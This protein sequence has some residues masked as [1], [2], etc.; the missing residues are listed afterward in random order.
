MTFGPLSS[1]LV[2]RFGCRIV[3]VTGCII[4]AISVLATSFVRNLSDMYGSFSLFYG[5]GTCLCISPIMTIA[6]DYFDKYITVAV[7]IITAGSSIGTLVMAPLSQVLIDTIGWRN[8]FRFFTGTCIF[9]AVC[10]SF[11]KPVA[12]KKS[13]LQ[14]LR[15]SPARLL[16]QELK[17]WKNRVFV[18]WTMAITCVMFGFYIP[19]VHL[20]SYAIT[21]GVSPEKGSIIVMIL[22]GCTAFGRVFF[23]KVVQSGILNRLHMHQLSMV[24]TGTGV[25]LLPLIKSFEGIIVYVLCV[26][27]VDGCYVVLLPVL[28]ATLVGADN[29]VLAWGFL[30]GTSSITFTLGP[31]VAGAL[32]D[33][34]GSYNVAFHCAGIPIIGGALLLLLIP[35]AQRT[36][37]SNNIMITISDSRITDDYDFADDLLE[38]NRMAKSNMST[39]TLNADQSTG[40]VKSSDVKLIPK[41]PAKTYRDQSTLTSPGSGI[42]TADIHHALSLLHENASLLATILDQKKDEIQAEQNKDLLRSTTWSRS[43]MLQ[44]RMNALTLLMNRSGKCIHRLAT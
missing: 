22:G 30:V 2:N 10:C 21:V 13:P 41:T 7:G 26:G 18:I 4:C 39:M 20:V 38:S 43:E 27:L 11:V 17:L 34:F 6:P 9:S 32:Y 12:K 14:N 23:G 29:A 16:M 40:N 5:L 1:V 3:M 31:P 8:T 19:Y 44:K 37:Q 25:M 36:S 15:Q 28:T 35:W 42:G 33:A 24:V